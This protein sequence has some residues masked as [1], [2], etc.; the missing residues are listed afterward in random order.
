MRTIFVLIDEC[1][2][3][4]VD[5][6]QQQ[7]QELINVELKDVFTRFT[8]DVIATTAFGIKCDSLKDRNNEFLL[9][10]RELADF[11]GLKRFVFFMFDSYPRIAKVRKCAN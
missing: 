9:A 5:Y 3:Q 8:N 6:Y 4:L 10:G 7:D 11:G 1:V 2:N